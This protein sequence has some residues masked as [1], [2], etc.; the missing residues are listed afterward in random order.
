MTV[1]YICDPIT[2]LAFPWKVSSFT[3]KRKEIFDS[4]FASMKRTT[5]LKLVERDWITLGLASY[6]T[7]GK[8]K[9]F[10]FEEKKDLLR[11]QRDLKEREEVLFLAE[12]KNDFLIM[13]KDLENRRE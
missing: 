10:L 8:E 12:R 13:R 9:Q 4:T 5:A 3:L 11:F 2:S 1:F 6:K 7:Q